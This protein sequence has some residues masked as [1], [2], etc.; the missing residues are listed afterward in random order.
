MIAKVWFITGTSSGFGR[1]WARAAL[2]RGDKVVATARN[3]GALSD[4][5]DR[6]GPA[7]LVRELDVTDRA[8]VFRVVEEAQAHFGRIDIVVSNAG[9]SYTGAVEELDIDEVKANFETN[10]FGTLSLVQAVLPVLRAQGG[11]HILTV[12]SIGGLASFPTGG[13][14]VPSKFA[15]EALSEALAG[16][17]AD[18]GIKVTIIEPGSYTTGFG[19]AARSATAQ[20]RYDTIRQSIRASFDPAT[21]GDPAA[22]AQAILAVVDADEPPLRLILGDWVLG[23][24]EQV[25]T[26]RIAEWQNWS[27][28]SNAAQR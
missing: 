28:I 24:I 2:E 6:F 18:Q 12:S 5:V 14:Y 15:I 23:R 10:V 7:V 26:D 4:L 25:Y 19:H 16:E 8:A 1:I 9:Y 21:T 17:V 13:A 27:A 22:T 20:G 3:A 11:G